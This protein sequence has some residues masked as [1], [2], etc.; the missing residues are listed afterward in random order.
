M[1]F[2]AEF[3]IAIVS[4]ALGFKL[5]DSWIKNRKVK[6]SELEIDEETQEKLKHLHELEER[7]RVLEKILTD[8]KYDLHREFEKL[9]EE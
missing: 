6:P 7:V 5:V 8:S 3:V 1:S 9:K 2:G 4:I